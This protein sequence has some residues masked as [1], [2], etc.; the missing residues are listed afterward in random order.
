MDRLP[1]SSGD[2]RGSPRKALSITL[3]LVWLKCRHFEWDW[4]V[5]FS[6]SVAGY[7]GYYA[8]SIW[9]SLNLEHPAVF[10]TSPIFHNGI[11][12]VTNYLKDRLVCPISFRHYGYKIVLCDVIIY[13]YPSQSSGCELWGFYFVVYCCFGCWFSARKMLRGQKTIGIVFKQ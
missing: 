3:R 9:R 8:W 13:K 7:D 10:S 2:S 6:T 1:I 5:T 12:L 4:N 11:Q